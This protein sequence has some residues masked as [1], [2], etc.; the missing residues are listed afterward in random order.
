M[1]YLQ[2]PLAYEI[3]TTSYCNGR[4]IIC[5]H[6]DVVI[7][8]QHMNQELFEKIIDE[9]NELSRGGENVLIIPYL[10]G[11]PLMDPQICQRL[12]IIR[13]KL[14]EC[15]IELSTNLSLLQSSILEAIVRNG[16]DDL[17][18]SCFGWEDS[19][20]QSMPGLDFDC[21][22]KQLRLLLDYLK[23]RGMLHIVSITVVLHPLLRQSDIKAIKTLAEQ[24]KIRLN[25][26]GALDRAGNVSSFRNTVNISDSDERLKRYTCAQRRHLERMHILANG[27]VVLCCQDWRRD[28]VLGNA[29]KSS[30]QT[31]WT[32]MDYIEIRS[33]IDEPNIPYPELCKK[34]KILIE[35]AK[36]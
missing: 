14:P 20:H 27:D 17:R 5:P 15:K 24:E 3:Q 30:L 34:C 12:D 11:E 21:F 35:G 31:I 28:I 36:W 19:Y 18:I 7:N 32:N 33:A 22:Q 29:L 13:D 8:P 10:N 9:I 4:C 1:N 26:W 23:K 2:Q 6:R 25:M 16:V